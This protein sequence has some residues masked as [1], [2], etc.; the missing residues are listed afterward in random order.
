[1]LFRS[2]LER[3][4][5]AGEAFNFS[6]ENPM[7]VIKLVKNI[8]MQA[9]K[10]PDYVILNKAQYEIKDQYLASAKARKILEW[11]PKYKLEEGLAETISWYKTYYEQK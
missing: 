1:M 6:D 10:K 3:K 7:N 11:K 8:F 5:L 9:G 2:Q 4:D